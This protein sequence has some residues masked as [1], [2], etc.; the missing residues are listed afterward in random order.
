MREE[1]KFRWVCHGLNPE[2]N[3]VQVARGRVVHHNIFEA[4]PSL[5]VIAARVACLSIAGSFGLWLQATFTPCCFGSEL[6]WG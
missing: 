1:I 3:A 4:L 5:T 6:C 2:R